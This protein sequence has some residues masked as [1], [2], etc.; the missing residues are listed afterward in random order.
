MRAENKLQLLGGVKLSVRIVFI[1]GSKVFS[2]MYEYYLFLFINAYCSPFE[3]VL[4]TCHKII[5]VTLVG[6]PH[7][8]LGRS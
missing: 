5:C 2:K 8:E 3:S 1:S 4:G 7:P 6:C